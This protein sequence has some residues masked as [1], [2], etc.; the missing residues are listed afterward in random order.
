MK[1]ETKQKLVNDAMAEVTGYAHEEVPDMD[2]WMS[3]LY[4]NEKNI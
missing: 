1:D 4:P 2:S 3:R